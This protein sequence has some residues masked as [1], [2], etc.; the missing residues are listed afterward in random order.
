MNTAEA[1]AYLAAQR[2]EADGPVAEM[3]DIIAAEVRRT[4]NPTGV[5]DR[6]LYLF[7]REKARQ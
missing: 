6:L 4:D 3:L 7:G 1:L 2:Q 5:A